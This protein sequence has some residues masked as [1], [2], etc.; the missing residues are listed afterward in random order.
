MNEG[1]DGS[2]GNQR[3]AVPTQAGARNCVSSPL[4][5]PVLPRSD[6]PMETLDLTTPTHTRCDHNLTLDV[7][8][9]TRRRR[10]SGKR[11]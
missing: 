7:T 9:P 4:S 3:G 8:T 11:T 10:L 6:F 1:Q 5:C 2:A